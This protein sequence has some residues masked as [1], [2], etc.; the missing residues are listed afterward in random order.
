MRRPAP[1]TVR[2]LI[3]AALLAVAAESGSAVLESTWH[4]SRAVDDSGN[5]F[6]IIEVEPGISVGNEQIVGIAFAPTQPNRML[7]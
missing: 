6:R 4:R 3:L 2:W 1:S 5:I 7:A